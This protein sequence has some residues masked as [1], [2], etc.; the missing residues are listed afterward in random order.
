[1]R[2]WNFGSRG[3]VKVSTRSMK[4][5]FALDG[6]NKA[7]YSIVNP[8]CVLEGQYDS[9]AFFSHVL[10]GVLLQRL[11]VL[12]QYLMSRLE[13]VCILYSFIQIL[14]TLVA[15]TQKGILRPLHSQRSFVFCTEEECHLNG[16]INSAWEGGNLQLASN[17]RSGNSHTFL[18]FK[19]GEIPL[20]C[21]DTPA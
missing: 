21:S 13:L 2:I 6:E 7:S 8:G 1:M 12:Y 4:I 14:C 16:H 19:H 9:S 3:M 15:G 18:S 20:H 10:A 17:Y 11:R 5:L